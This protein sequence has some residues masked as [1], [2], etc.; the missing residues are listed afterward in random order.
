MADQQQTPNFNNAG[1]GSIPQLY[2]DGAAQVHVI[3]DM[4]KIDMY[5]QIPLTPTSVGPAITGRIIMPLQAY[6]QFFELMKDINQK[7]IA[8]G[9]IEEAK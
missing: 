1:D 5:T 7:L 6:L 4:V 2:A 3:N 9:T 8:N